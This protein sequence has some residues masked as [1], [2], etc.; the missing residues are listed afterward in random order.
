MT[1]K[2]FD[3]NEYSKKALLTMKDPQLVLDRLNE[4]GPKAV[5]LDNGA[6]GLTDEVG[7]ISSCIKKH[8]EYGQELDRSN[9]MEEIGDALW[10]LNQIADAAG[11][12]LQEAAMANLRKL[13][14]HRY[15]EGYSDE[16]A[17][18]ENRDLESENS[19]MVL[20]SNVRKTGE[21]WLEHHRW[22]DY[23][24]YPG[25]WEQAFLKMTDVILEE[26]F[27]LLFK[28]SELRMIPNHP[29][30]SRPLLKSFNEWCSLYEIEVGKGV[31]AL[32][33]PITLEYYF[34]L[35]L[36]TEHKI[37]ANAL[38]IESLK[39]MVKTDEQST[40]GN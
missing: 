4:L 17:A 10:R 35:L 32:D 7:E 15:K 36:T 18:D 30:V 27:L 29:G 13:Q 28:R 26:S 39:L 31:I 11:I 6:R 19:E 12:P 9:L 1:M 34:E 24:A 8:I 37:K 25:G 23:L 20:R 3:F 5:Q 40:E 21:G 16:A 22:K 14:S 33:H 2:P 38:E